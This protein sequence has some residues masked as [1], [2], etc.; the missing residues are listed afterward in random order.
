MTRAFVAVKLP[1]GVLAAVAT[2]TEAVNVRGGRKTKTV[3]WHLTL[4]FLGDDADVD[5]VVKA[6]EEFHVPGGR[7]RLGGAG[8]FPNAQRGRI[9]WIGVLDGADVVERLAH[10]V[11]ER[12][13]PLGFVP[14]PREFVPHITLVRSA[15]PTDFRAPIAAI[16]AGPIG[17]AWEIDE[18]TLY[19]SQL[20]AAGARYLERATIPLP[21]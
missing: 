21:G 19:E 11:A 4:Q 1:P 7:A 8:A 18:V 9:L 5:A 14:E 13:A 20:R 17:D 2:A 16:G 15:R 12:L 6:L 10:G 3:Q